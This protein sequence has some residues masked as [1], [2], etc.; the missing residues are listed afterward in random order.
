MPIKDPPDSRMGGKG[1]TW[2]QGL[3]KELHWF[4]SAHEASMFATGYWCQG[5]DVYFGLG[6]SPKD[7]GTH[8][9]CS[10]TE[11]AGFPGFWLKIS[12]NG[13]NHADENMPADKAAIKAML[14]EFPLEPSFVVYSGGGMH[15]H[16]KFVSPWLFVSAEQ[17]WLGRQA[18]KAFVETF[19][20]SAIR[21]GFK[22]DDAHNLA[23]VL[24]LPGCFNYTLNPPK[25][26]E[27]IAASGKEYQPC[28]FIDCLFSR[29]NA[30]PGLLDEPRN[31]VV[32]NVGDLFIVNEAEPPDEI[33]SIMKNDK[34]FK[35]SWER[36]RRDIMD[37]SSA[38]Y[39][40][41]IAAMA[42]N[43]GWDDQ[44]IINTL[45]AHRRLHGDDLKFN[46]SSYYAR[47]IKKVRQD[48]RR[49]VALEN[50]MLLPEVAASEVPDNDIRLWAL[51]NLRI[52]LEL[53]IIR[54]VRYNSDSPQ[55]EIFTPEGNIWF[56]SA[57]HLVTERLFKIAVAASP[58]GIMLSDMQEEWIIIINAILKAC[59]V[60]DIDGE[61]LEPKGMKG[62]LLKCL[63][64]MYLQNSQ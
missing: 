21:H 18:E 35:M 10:S 64:E 4:S 32:Y 61:S 15:A 50:L 24:R 12:R 49:A 45:I 53:E 41:C 52:R 26:V 16:W 48:E 40:K 31:Q 13:E 33:W 22:I 20:A 5:C 17:R 30:G 44:C 36:K 3:F 42:I 7:Y 9:R 43:Y 14:A 29:K 59:E 19:R 60:V 55:Y 27:L 56:K 37:Q 58:V 2:G 63:K 54:I 23:S 34:K 1:G 62:R 38:S 57:E 39:D 11:V 6:I 28:E 51:E 8:N 25:K 47:I 46:H